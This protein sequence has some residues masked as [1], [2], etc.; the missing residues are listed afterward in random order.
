MDEYVIKVVGAQEYVAPRGSGTTNIER[1][2]VFDNYV[3][4]VKN[5]NALNLAHINDRKPRSFEIVKKR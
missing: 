2:Y 5:V 3:Q 4:A 1:A